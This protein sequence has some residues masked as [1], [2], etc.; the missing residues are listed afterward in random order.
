MPESDDLRRAH[1]H[2][3]QNRIQ[4]RRSF[5]GVSLVSGGLGLS[6][7]DVFRLRAAAEESRG[8]SAPQDTAVIQIWLGGGIS[9]FESWDPKP[10]APRG[11]RGPWKPLATNLPGVRFCELLPQQARIADKLAIIRSCYHTDSGHGQATT[12]C[13]TG[14]RPAGHP[15]NGS[16]T[17]KLKGSNGFGVPAYVQLKEPTTANPTFLLNFNAH[18][19]GGGCDPFNIEADPAAPKFQV[20]NLKLTS[21]LTLDRLDARHGL[22]A[23]FDRFSRLTESSTALE[24]MDHFQQSAFE[25][26]TAPRTRDAFD[27]TREDPKLRERYGLHRWGQSALLARRLVEAGVTFVTINTGPDSIY[28]DIHGGGAGTVTDTMQD[29]CGRLDS[30]VSTLVED[31]HQRGLDRKVLLLVWGEFGRTPKI[32]DRV[33]RDHWPQVASLLLA[34]GG[35]RVGQVIGS[36]DAIGGVPASRPVMPEDVLATVYRHLGIDPRTH[37]HDLD[38]RPFPILDRGEVIQ[39]LL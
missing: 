36:S 17:T 25:L 6:L 9:Q 34:G 37:L 14:K 1:S 39:E 29:G 32:N 24:S 16:I 18:Y 28:W 30:M 12:L 5:L 10:D 21:G 23:A 15:S 35:L 20:P 33:G 8:A 19:L 13:V 22:L 4:S 26:L 11:I 7:A 31:I 3:L 38:G 27:L 2:R